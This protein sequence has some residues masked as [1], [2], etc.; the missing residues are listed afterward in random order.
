M[1]TLE[2]Y[3]AEYLEYCKYRKR[4]DAKSLKA[5][6]IDLKQYHSFS[7]NL[8]DALSRNTIDYFITTL[9]K[10]YKPKTVRRKIASLKA[11]FHYLE[12]I[13]SP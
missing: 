3:I 11:F 13:E 8:Q 10:Q 1:N 12:Y 5:Y 4:L 7:C 2:N 6:Q 9:H